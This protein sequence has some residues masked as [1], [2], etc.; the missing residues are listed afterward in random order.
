[1]RRRRRLRQATDGASGA[2]HG[3]AAAAPKRT[4]PLSLARG[5]TSPAAAAPR[6]GPHDLVRG[7]RARGAAMCPSPRTRRPVRD[8]RRRGAEPARFRRGAPRDVDRPAPRLPAGPQTSLAPPALASR[9]AT[10]ATDARCAT[11]DVAA[12]NRR[13]PLGLGRVAT[14]PRWEV[15]QRDTRSYH[16]KLRPTRGSFPWTGASS[17]PAPVP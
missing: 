9:D 15:W 12:P 8:E 10:R 7:A 3:V 4:L 13:R 14:S 6:A 5:E 2:A 17:A 11:N 16:P 1:M